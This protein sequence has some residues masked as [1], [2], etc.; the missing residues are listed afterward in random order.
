MADIEL[1]YD[2]IMQS[3]LRHVVKDVLKITADLNETP[4]DHHFY[5][6]FLTEAE[7]VDIPD[8]LRQTYPHKMTVVL[9]H[10]FEDLV[11][12]EDYF[13]VSLWF[14]GV[15]ARLTIPFAAMTSFADPSEKFGLRFQEDDFADTPEDFP[16]EDNG[17]DA[18]VT[19]MKTGS[20]AASSSGTSENDEDDETEE[21]DSSADV[22]SLDAFRKK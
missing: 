14:K 3:A 11:V 1:D 19:S 8:H 22:V 2:S 12:E 13:A 17:E 6:E 9:H 20:K 18:G 16:G 15:E 7:G 5:I 4:G 21:D 10:Q